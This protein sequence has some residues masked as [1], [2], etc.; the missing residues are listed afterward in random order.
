[1]HV[2]HTRL[3]NGLEIIAELNEHAHSV[4]LGFF[5]RT[6]SR[7]E[8]PEDEGISH[9]LE[10]MIFKGTQKR[11][12]LAVNRDLDRI[13]A[14]H[15]AQ[16]S[17]EDTVYYLAC[18]PEYFEPA[19]DILADILRPALRDEDFETEKQVIL[20]EIQ[21]YLD[22]PMSV[23][24]E[25][26]KALHFQAHPLARSVLGTPETIGRMRPAA[27]RSYFT[28]RYGPSNIVLAVAGN[29]DWSQIERLARSR[30]AA[31][32][33]PLAERAT[34]S[35]RGSHACRAIPR[36]DDQT[37]VL[38]GLADAPCLESPDRYAASLLATILGD[39]IGSR[40]YWTLVEPGLADAAELSFQD[41]NQAGAYITVLSCD[42]ELVEENLARLQAALSAFH[43]API[44]HDELTAARNKVMARSVVRA[45]RPM[46]RLWSLGFHWTYRREYMSLDQE[47]DELNRVELEDLH[48]LL[49]QFPLW[50]QT[51]VATGPREHLQ[52]PG[53]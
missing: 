10:H 21:M 11:D 16:T 43:D 36:A 27:M 2:H 49:E 37:E 4:G 50:P 42:P 32:E 48:R 45:E 41:F 28:R 15:N 53:F 22:Q 6:G 52:F 44:T 47:L 51:L 35:A 12:A 19:L 29:A 26:A 9:F 33:G 46:G 39:H 23:A 38:I 18:L 17:E 5:V 20:E 40:L 24:Y 34:P 1:M 30:C 31:W 14:K 7:D 3:E 8:S 25:A 13:G